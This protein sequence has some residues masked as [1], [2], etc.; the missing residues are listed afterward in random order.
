MKCYPNSLS[1]RTQKAR[2]LSNPHGRSRKTTAR[3]REDIWPEHHPQKQRN[4]ESAR[5]PT[6]RIHLPSLCLD[7]FSKHAEGCFV[8]ASPW[9]RWHPH[10]KR[11]NAHV[12]LFLAK[13]G[14]SA[15][16]AALE[17][18]T[19]A[20]GLARRKPRR[21]KRRTSWPCWPRPGD[22]LAAILG[23]FSQSCAP[24]CAL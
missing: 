6:R 10:S 11:G 22:F 12:W 4:E 7:H 15:G 2:L 8:L 20:V 24:F 14:R 18:P 19:W 13:R 1:P 23:T 16:G 21:Q 17:K 3:S 9:R 5:P